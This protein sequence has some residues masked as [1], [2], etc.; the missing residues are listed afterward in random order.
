MKRLSANEIRKSW[1]D[2]F[3]SKGHYE[4]PSAS[5]IPNNDPSLLW[6]N[7]GVATL[8]PYFSGIQKPI[9]NRLVSSQKCIRTNDIENVGITS[10]HH[11]FFEMLGNFSIGD[12]FKKEAIEFAYEYLVKVL[13]MDVN[14]LY[15][16]VYKEDNDAY[17]YWIAMGIN[18]SHIFLGDKNR[19]FW[20]VGNGPCGPCTE[21]YYDRGEKFDPNKQGI[22]L[23]EKDIE[24][25]RYVEIWNVVFSQY[26]NDGKNNYTEL[27]QKNI[28]TGCGLERLACVMQDV[29]TNYDSD[30]F[31]NII[32][33]AQKY[34]N[35][36]KYNS[37]A[38]FS[39]DKK[40]KWINR[41]Y[42]VIVDHLKASTFAIADGGQPSGKDRGAV[43]RKLIRRAIVCA[44]F[45]KLKEGWLD[46]VIDAIVDTNKV[47]YPYLAER[48]DDIK[49]IIAQE[50]NL[51]QRTFTNG[52]KLFEKATHGRK[53][54]SGSDAFKLTD[55]YG[56]PYEVILSMCNDNDIKLNIKEYQEQMSEHQADSGLKTNIK[57]MTSQNPNLVNFTM[58]SYFDYDKLKIENSKII[59]MFDNQFE[60]I[61]SGANKVW[62]VFE[63]TVFYATSG[64]Q[65]HDSGYIVIND[66]KYSV[67]NVIKGPNGQHLHLIDVDNN[68]I[69]VGD[70]ATLV[71]DEKNRLDTTR[72]HSCEHLLQKALQESISKSIYQQ[73]ASKNA[74]RVTFDFSYNDKLTT[75]KIVKAENKVN[76]YIQT[77]APVTISEMT[78]EEAK[79][80]GAKAYFEKVYSKLGNKLRVVNME[81]VTAEI[82]AGT[83][84][85][86][87]GDIQEYMI[88]DFETKGA[89]FYR[90]T[91]ISGKDNI[92]KFLTK[93]I[94]EIKSK[95]DKML[96]DLKSKNIKNQ[97]FDVLI[98]KLSFDLNRTNYHKLQDQIIDVD[99]AYKD[100]LKE[101]VRS[102]NVDESNNLKNE[103]SKDNA[104]NF[105]QFK[106]ADKKILVNALN[107]LSKEN[108]DKAFI[109]LNENGPKLS[110]VI[111]TGINSKY[112]ATDII[113]EIN[114][115]CQGFGGGNNNFAQGGTPHGEKKHEVVKYLETL[116]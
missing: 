53:E 52:I 36:M 51:F 81:G 91:G 66:N 18:K 37:E 100:L 56:F 16:T 45:L 116:K 57:A 8:K 29:P 69:N 110:Y 86:N 99:N 3:K 83:H 63:D 62:L 1:L 71:V 38:Y 4:M 10:R 41:N 79:K 17:D 60:P 23:L 46:V 58:T 107:M 113:N 42:I 40:Q 67:I 59:A 96:L 101:Y 39:S 87:L 21:I 50:N 94:G 35:D 92:N 90:I 97:E 12:Y 15:I 108:V 2:F 30:F 31:V 43:L 78:L 55:T 34:A 9:C 28:D 33:R 44:W 77:K 98:G 5:L 104:V 70:Y 48:K 105:K 82:C 111:T 61:A 11:T 93:S 54:L 65:K 13:E 114:K 27:A 109:A 103:F 89:G 106:D 14:K 95:V 49:R 6:I 115:I 75:D 102:S 76:E 84:V 80:L 112:K 64:G 85:K 26:N 88:V 7:S 24:N 32:N 72:N 19:N 22:K 68:I 74:E 20:D 73:G 47:Y 25:D